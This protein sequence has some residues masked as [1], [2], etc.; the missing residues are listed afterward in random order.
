MEGLPIEPI[1]FLRPENLPPNVRAEIR[2]Q[3]LV[4]G[5]M[6]FHQND[7]AT[8]IYVV[9]SGRIRLDS[10]TPEGK[11][12][13]LQIVRSKESFAV[14]SLFDRVYE[15]NATSEVPSRVI[16]Y[17]KQ[18]LLGTLT[19]N[20]ELAQEL[21]QQLVKHIYALKMRLELR[22][23]RAAHDRVLHYLKIIAH[24]GGIVIT[25]DRPLKMVAL[26]LGLTPEV[27]YR[28][29]AQLERR[30]AISRTRR[31]ITLHQTSAA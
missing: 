23:I 24:F 27:F 21:M 25:F 17:P 8:A 26:D 14:M 6:L 3:N 18:I 22:E 4:A 20:P 1:E 5:E 28:T 2:Y 29:L 9:E 13:T 10:Y 19:Q 31:Q 16:V 7:P 30:G 12:V 11:F 15:T